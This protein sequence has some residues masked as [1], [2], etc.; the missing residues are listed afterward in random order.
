MDQID[1]HCTSFQIPSRL[2]ELAK[3]RDDHKFPEYLHCLGD[4][5]LLD[6]PCVAV[7]GTREPTERGYKI[8]HSIAAH[9]AELGCTIV[10]GLALGCDTAAHEGALSVGGK[11]IAALGTPLEQRYPVKNVGLKQRIVEQ[12]GLLITEY[13]T[14]AGDGQWGTRLYQRD[15]IQ[16]AIAHVVIPVQAGKKSGTLH[17]VGAAIKLKRPVVAPVPGKDVETDKYDGIIRLLERKQAFPLKGK[18]DYPRIVKS[19]RSWMESD[20]ARLVTEE[21]NQIWFESRGV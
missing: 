9:L 8:A 5:S 6:S 1:L 21:D 4:I 18:E 3:I 2:R 14:E 17:T 19:I 12:G 20:M 11:T 13:D 7:I 15:L 16:A 10:A